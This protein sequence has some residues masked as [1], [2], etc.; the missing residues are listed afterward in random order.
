MLQPGAN[1]AGAQGVRNWCSRSGAVARNCGIMSGMRKL[2]ENR[3]NRVYH[4]MS[5]IAM[6]MRRV[7]SSI[8]RMWCFGLV[9]LAGAQTPCAGFCEINGSVQS[10]TSV[11]SILSLA[12][13]SPTNLSSQ[14]VVDQDDGGFVL[15]QIVDHGYAASDAGKFEGHVLGIE[16]NSTNSVALPVLPASI[17][18]VMLRGG[19]FDLRN[20]GENSNVKYF[21]AECVSLNVSVAGICKRFPCAEMMFVDVFDLNKADVEVDSLAG[22]KRLRRLK[23]A[24][25]GAAPGDFVRRLVLNMP[26]LERLTVSGQYDIGVVGKG[27]SKDSR[28]KRIDLSEALAANVTGIVEVPDFGD[29]T[30][31]NLK[32]VAPDTH[33]I[34]LRPPVGGNKLHS[35]FLEL[36]NVITTGESRLVENGF[37]IYRIHIE[38]ERGR[39]NR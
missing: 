8:G 15:L 6:M 10:A 5:R 31:M 27:W 32:I 13:S 30:G 19:S 36:T 16:N 4:P 9:I 11:E 7:M 25:D 35:L 1:T 14:F 28:I 21:S 2:C 33:F 34:D 18:A 29:Y 38:C 23:L 39:R 3:H 24:H 22:L 37:V 26:R 12:A 20:L 17:E